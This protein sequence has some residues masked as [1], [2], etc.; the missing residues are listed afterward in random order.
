M[1]QVLN[2][3]GQYFRVDIT[4]IANPM[5]PTSPCTSVGAAMRSMN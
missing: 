1:S 4:E 2:Y 3:D 5:T